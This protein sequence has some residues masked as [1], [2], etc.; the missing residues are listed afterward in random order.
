MEE[1]YSL[2]S[3]QLHGERIMV[4]AWKTANGKRSTVGLP[5]LVDNASDDAPDGIVVWLL[6]V[7]GYDEAIVLPPDNSIG[8]AR[9]QCPVN[10]GNIA[11]KNPLVLP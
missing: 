11:V 1:V 4:N 3:M 10:D 5:E 9:R 2:F 6:G 7:S 8:F